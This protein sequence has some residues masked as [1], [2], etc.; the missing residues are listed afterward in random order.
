MLTFM[1]RIHCVGGLYRPMQTIC[2]D[3]FETHEAGGDNLGRKWGY[4][5]MNV[6]RA[7]TE[8]R[9]MVM[10]ETHMG[11]SQARRISRL[12]DRGRG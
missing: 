3:R 5:E 10:G 9:K 8:D 12:V 4:V 2:D 6:G 1:Y 11:A 7:K